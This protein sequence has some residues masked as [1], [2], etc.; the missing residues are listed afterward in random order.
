MGSWN[1]VMLYDDAVQARYD[2]ISR[3]LYLGLTSA[4]VAGANASGPRDTIE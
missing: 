2:A 3:R 4:L 1:D